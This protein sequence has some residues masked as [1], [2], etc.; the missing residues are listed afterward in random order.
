MKK[1]ELANFVVTAGENGL[2]DLLETGMWPLLMHAKVSGKGEVRAYRFHDL[3]LEMV[4]GDLTGYPCLYGRLV[5]LMTLQAEQ[6]FDDRAKKI[7]PSEESVDSA[8]SSFFLI[9]LADHK[10]AFFPESRRRAPSL[11]DM[12][13]TVAGIL[14]EDWRTRRSAAERS[15]LAEVGRNRIPRGQRESWDQELARRFPEPEVRITPLAAKTEL[16]KRFALYDRVQT[17]EVRPFKTNNELADENAELLRKFVETRK[18]LG[19]T[20]DRIEL[21]NKKQGLNKEEAERLVTH[22]S[23][24]NFQVKMKGVDSSGRPLSDDLENMRIQIEYPVKRDE[25]ITSRAMKI[26]SIL[27][28]ALR[29]HAILIKEPTQLAIQRARDIVIR[30]RQQGDV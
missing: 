1:V 15:M 12:Q 26:L 9:S 28:E 8:P 29:N 27:L 7:V 22:A 25:V 17:V 30:L 10:L 3:R 24:G 14:H 16:R 6:Q 20:K 4:G 18:R 5:R 11:Q 19:S 23:D 2:L 13:F 21:S